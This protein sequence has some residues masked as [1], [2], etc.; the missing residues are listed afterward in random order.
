MINKQAFGWLIYVGFIFL[1][2]VCERVEATRSGLAMSRAEK[3]IKLKEARNE[4]MRFELA[5]LMSPAQLELAAKTRGMTSPEPDSV[6]T[7]A[8]L[9]SGSASSRWLAKLVPEKGVSAHQ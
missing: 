8:D 6:T 7:L 1:L 2:L 4:H 5:E 3:S 9:P